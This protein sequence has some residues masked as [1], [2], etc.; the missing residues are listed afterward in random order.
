[1]LV[2]YIDFFSCNNLCQTC[3]SFLVTETIISLTFL[4]QL[5]CIFQINAAGLT[6][7]LHIGAKA[8]ILVRTFIMDQTGLLERSV[9]DLNSALYQTLLI[10]IFNS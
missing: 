7:A 4:D 3:Q 10:G 2:I 8:A 1:M 5:F 9:N 6:L